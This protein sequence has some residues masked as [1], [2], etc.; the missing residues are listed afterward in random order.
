MSAF[1]YVRTLVRRGFVSALSFVV[2]RLI[3]P[4]GE[5]SVNLSAYSLRFLAV[6]DT[7][8]CHEEASA[9]PDRSIC[10][11]DHANNPAVVFLSTQKC[12]LK[13]GLVSTCNP[14]VKLAVR[15]G[16]ILCEGCAPED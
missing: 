4:N 13:D 7:H 10:L 8:T 3:E 16:R 14:F 1:P 2:R 15:F 12:A 11:W 9:K 6:N 5:L